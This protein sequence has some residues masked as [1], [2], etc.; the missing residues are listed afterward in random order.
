MSSHPS[1]RTL[2][3]YVADLLNPA[4][5]LSVTEHLEGCPACRDALT[6]HLEAEQLLYALAEQRRVSPAR[7]A[8]RFP[9]WAVAALLP[10]AAGLMLTLLSRPSQP[11]LPPYQ[12]ELAPQAATH[13]AAEPTDGEAVSWP[14]GASLVGVLRPEVD[15]PE[16]I[17]AVVYVVD[18][19][20][21]VS[22]PITTEA[23]PAGSL[24][25]TL[26]AWSPEQG[27]PREVVVHY[28]PR[29]TAPEAPT[30][31]ALPDGWV[32]RRTPVRA[33]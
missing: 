2:G 3:D 17:E 32:E 12:W 21:L 15:Y 4:E 31:G 7:P 14:P 26:P 9:V 1:P 5:H 8:R 29:G 16:G 25:V 13:R 6:G 20:G 30:G 23:S 28:G 18:D 33:P 10:L 27:P 11:N 19:R 22:W 24:R